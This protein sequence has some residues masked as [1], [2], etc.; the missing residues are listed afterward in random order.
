LTAA[1]LRNARFEG[2]DLTEAEVKGAQLMGA[3][4]RSTILT[5]VHLDDIRGSGVDLTDSITDENVGKSLETLGAPLARLIKEHRNWISSVGAEGAQL[6]LSGF[7]LRILLS[8]S[9]EKLTAL[10]AIEARWCGM[11]LT[12]IQLQSAHLEGSDFRSCF[13]RGADFR[14]SILKGARF[15]HADLRNANFSP[16][17]FESGGKKQA[18]ITHLEDT[19]LRYA[20][21]T[22]AMMERVSFKNADVAYANFTNCNLGGADFSGANIENVNFTGAHIE[23]AIFDGEPPSTAA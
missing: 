19:N 15:S 12:D 10:K 22:G 6:D 9:G 20:N 8:L 17:Y 2:A 1:D 7:D 3:N 14:A 23:G 13:L 5:G 21:C 11:D 18:S 4:M 16:L